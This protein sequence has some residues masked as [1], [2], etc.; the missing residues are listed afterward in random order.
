MRQDLSSHHF[1][2]ATVLPG[3]WQASY[4][5]PALPRVAESWSSWQVSSAP[6]SAGY[7]LGDT[8][9]ALAGPEAWQEGRSWLVLL[10]PPCRGEASRGRVHSVSPGPPGS[11]LS[12]SH[13]STCRLGWFSALS[14]LWVALFPPLASWFFQQL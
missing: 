11:A 12:C 14:H 10:P 7:L 8:H 9:E 3:R 5:N 4:P 13:P 1:R 6:E 2:G